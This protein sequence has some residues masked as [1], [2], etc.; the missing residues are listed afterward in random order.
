MM[1]NNIEG[2]KKF[3]ET[4]RQEEIE[5]LANEK[6]GYCFDI[7]PYAFVLGIASV[8]IKKIETIFNLQ[9]PSWYMGAMN[10]HTFRKFTDGM[11]SVSVPSTENG[12]ISKSSGGG[13]HVGG[14]H[15]GGGGHSW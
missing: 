2:F 9:E 5:R 3:L 13:G 11:K 10:A 8:W 1:L 14:G 7:L 15:G 6:P 4:A 12:G